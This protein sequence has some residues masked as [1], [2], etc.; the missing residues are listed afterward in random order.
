MIDFAHSFVFL[1]FFLFSFFFLMH[2]SFFIVLFSLCPDLT[3]DSSV[4]FQVVL[5][6]AVAVAVVAIALATTLCRVVVSTDQRADSNIPR[7]RWEQHLRP[8]GPH[9]TSAVK[10]VIVSLSVLQVAWEE[11]EGE[12]EETVPLV[13]SAVSS[14][15]DSLSVRME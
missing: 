4:V 7:Q 8:L 9:A 5:I 6:A 12:E 11:E 3:A 10:S 14:V 13:S 1:L 2:A 15:I